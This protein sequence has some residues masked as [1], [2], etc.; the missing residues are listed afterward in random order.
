MMQNRRV[1]L[2][3]VREAALRGCKVRVQIGWD[4]DSRS[5]T[6]RW[7]TDAGVD[8]GETFTAPAGVLEDCGIVGPGTG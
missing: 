6:L 7:I 5:R 3:R 1:V 4:E 2:Q 8:L